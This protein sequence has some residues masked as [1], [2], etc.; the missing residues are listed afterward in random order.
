[1]KATDWEFANRATIFGILLGCSFGFYVLDKEN[2]TV[3]LANWTEARW[4]VNA[5]I[6]AR[7]LFAIA[8]LI[9]VLAALVRTWAS[10]YLHAGV[11]YAAQVKSASLV[12]DG[13][14]RFVRN[15]LYFANVLM[16]IAF[17]FMMSRV[18]FVVV[19]V[20]MMVFCYR[21]I[22]REETELVTNQSE[23]YQDYRKVVPRLWPSPWPRIAGNGRAAKWSDGFK[24]EAWYWGFALALVVFAVTLKLSAFFVILALSLGLFWF[25]ASAM[26]K[27][28]RFSG[29]ANT[30]Q[31]Q[32]SSD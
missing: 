23:S 27:K 10:S 15:P 11:V 24:A 3:V 13:P 31:K 29:V 30:D 26:E 25:S 14:Y 2:I 8:A 7:I 18:G 4:H 22:F 5:D 1:M 21:L 6:V 20:A 28:S 17:G 9:M 32:Q 19:V 12:A 16:A